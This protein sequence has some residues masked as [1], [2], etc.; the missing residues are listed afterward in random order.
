MAVFLKALLYDYN[1]KWITLCCWLKIV[2]CC[3]RQDVIIQVGLVC[4]EGCAMGSESTYSIKYAAVY[5]ELL[6][7]VMRIVHVKYCNHLLAVDMP[8]VACMGL[9]ILVKTDCLKVVYTGQEI[10][11]CTSSSV[12]S[13]HKCRFVLIS[14]GLL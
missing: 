8:G 4:V 6:C 5:D 1:L 12:S 3:Y 7:E 2:V 9:I 13:L 11:K 14:G 10:K